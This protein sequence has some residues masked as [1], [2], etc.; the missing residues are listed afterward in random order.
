MDS[1]PG[2]PPDIQP[3]WTPWVTFHVIHVQKEGALYLID[4]GM[5]GAIPA[6][7]RTLRQRHWEHLPLRGIVLTHGH[8]DHT[9]NVAELAR[10]TGAWVAAPRLDKLHC[11]GRF[12]Y[13]GWSRVCGWLEAC[14]RRLLGF[15]PFPVDHWIDD[16][17]TIPIGTGWTAVHLP[18]HTNG[19]MGYHHAGRKLLYTGDLFA[20]FGAF[21]HL[22]PRILNSDPK[23]LLH[24]LHRA[25]SLNLEGALPNHGWPASPSH[26]LN[27][28]HRL[29]RRHLI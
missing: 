7:H 4:T 21:S 27:Q 1:P 20:S 8:Y 17:D 24:S 13:R 16:G 9:R 6:L 28:L 10:E 14:G 23:R 26:H 11:E 3:V 18:G 29:A 25:T 19:H 22:P 2:Y 12:P 15:R 5:V